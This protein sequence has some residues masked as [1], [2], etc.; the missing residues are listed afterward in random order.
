[1]ENKYQVHIGPNQMSNLTIDM[2]AALWSCNAEIAAENTISITLTWERPVFQVR[3]GGG[4][5]GPSQVPSGASWR[6]H[7]WDFQPAGWQLSPSHYY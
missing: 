4:R 7:L 2:L 1:M 3:R 5:R 6:E